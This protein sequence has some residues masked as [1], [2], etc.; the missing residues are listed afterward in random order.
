MVALAA[1]L[2]LRAFTA[3]R[4]GMRLAGPPPPRCIQ[5]SVNFTKKIPNLAS[6]FAIGNRDLSA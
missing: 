5:C 6:T 4:G 1:I 2:R 3:C